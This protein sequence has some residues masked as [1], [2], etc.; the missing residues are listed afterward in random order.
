MSDRTGAPS[1]DRGAVLDAARYFDRW[2][3]FRQRYDR[4]PGIQAAVLHGDEVVLSCAHGL[5]DVEAGTPLTTRHLFR[6]ASHSKTF[7]ATAVLQLVD[8]GDLRL[9]DPVSRWLPFLAG[10]DLATVTVRELLGH[11]GG[12]VR[13]GWDGD[14]WQL[15][16]SFPD[17]AELERIAM[18]DAAVLSRNERFKYS[19]IGFSL[20][21]MVVAAAS[22]QRYDDYVRDHILGPLGLEDTGPDLDPARAEDY[23]TGYSALAYADRRLPID[24]VPTGA[25]ASATGFYSTASDVVRYAAAH[26]HGDV[27]LLS[28]D[29]K[30]LAQRTEWEVAEN[31]AYGL[32][33]AVTKVGDRRLLG[34]GGGYPGHITFTM[35]DPVERFAVSVLTNAIDGGARGMATAFVR[36]LDLAANDG[37]D[38][39]DADLSS[40]R[41]RFANLWAVFDVA[42]LGG[43]LYRMDPTVPDPV[44]EPERLAVVDP[45]TLR[46]EEASGYS[47][48]GERLVYD[49]AADGTVRSV[50]GGSGMRSYPVDELTRAVDGR[51]RVTPAEPLLP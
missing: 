2:L 25:M 37:A 31:Q 44:A 48:P 26:F 22:A 50:R 8:R 11:G 34:H 4:I 33:F 39:A 14:F 42:D 20:L 41:G 9:D 35:F 27:R 47:S 29:A 17:A 7:T 16:R 45:D 21:G 18:D 23:A 32:G 12:L 46:F 49:R 28:A 1:I 3:A 43:R 36:L 19:N 40:F 38:P 6:I 15:H 13:D 10:S 30:R 5:A 51:D 24:L